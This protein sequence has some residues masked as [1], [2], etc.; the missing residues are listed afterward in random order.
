MNDWPTII[1]RAGVWAL[2]VIA[3]VAVA[4]YFHRDFVAA[5]AE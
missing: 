1:E 5:L 2:I 3:M 4:L